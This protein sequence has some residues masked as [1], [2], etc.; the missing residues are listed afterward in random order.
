VTSLLDQR[1][2]RAIHKCPPPVAQYVD[3][4]NKLRSSVAR[5][6][7]IGVAAPGIFRPGLETA[8]RN[9]KLP[10]PVEGLRAHTAVLYIL[11]LRR[12][13]VRSISHSSYRQ[14]PKKLKS[15]LERYFALK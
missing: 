1:V 9:R 15:G 6:A 4:I 13:T 11:H 7:F 2:A 3:P 12:H 10:L 14:Q 8:I 5:D